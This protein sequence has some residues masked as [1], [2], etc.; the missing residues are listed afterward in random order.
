MRV[1]YRMT[2]V[3]LVT[4]KMLHFWSIR[5]FILNR[6][7][8]PIKCKFYRFFIMPNV[9]HPSV[10][11]IEGL[12]DL[13]MRRQRFKIWIFFFE[14]VKLSKFY[15]LSAEK[16]CKKFI[17]PVVDPWKSCKVNG[18]LFLWH[19]M[20]PLLFTR[21]RKVKRTHWCT[22]ANGYSQ[23]CIASRS[24][25]CHQ[26]FMETSAKCTARSGMERRKTFLIIIIIIIMLTFNP[27]AISTQKEQPIKSEWLLDVFS[28]RLAT[29]TAAAVEAQYVRRKKYE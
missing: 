22:L 8:F 1:K 25:H 21:W 19:L 7:L 16:V 20:R 17:S 2:C 23:H 15:G 4:F 24:L 5:R 9:I 18:I 6:E 26:L 29:I 13:L 3:A 28:G 12:S 27:E 14:T 11:Y 10:I